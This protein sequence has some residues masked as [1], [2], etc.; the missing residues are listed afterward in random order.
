MPPPGTI[1]PIVTIVG[2]Y[3][4]D[5]TFVGKRFPQPGETIMAERL[6]RGPG[7]KGSNQAI[8]AA[9]F[10]AD[11]RLVARLGDDTAGWE[12]LARYRQRD[13][14]TDNIHMDAAQATGAAVILVNQMRTSG[15]TSTIFFGCDGTYG[16]DFVDRS[17]KNGE[18]T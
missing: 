1:R 8:A 4:Q 14:S 18:G 17:K 6:V 12:D 16:Q 3:N 5:L 7:G 15:L 9:R 2:S 13:I 11:T 10:G